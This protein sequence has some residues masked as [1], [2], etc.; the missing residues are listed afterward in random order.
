MQKMACVHE[1][2]HVR[3]RETYIISKFTEPFVII[4]KHT[5]YIFSGI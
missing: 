2:H 1:Q 5:R 4:H 3:V